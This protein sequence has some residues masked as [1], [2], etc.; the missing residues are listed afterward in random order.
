MFV[1]YSKDKRQTAEQ[2]GQRSMD[3][4]QR[5]GEKILL[6]VRFFAPVQ[7]GPG[8]HSARVRAVQIVFP[9]GKE[10]GAWHLPPSPSSAEFI[11]NNSNS[12]PPVDLRGLFSGKIYLLLVMK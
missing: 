5:E 12:T 4:V 9:E 11:R 1:L 2:P 6:Q 7:T 10:A 8:A 3:K